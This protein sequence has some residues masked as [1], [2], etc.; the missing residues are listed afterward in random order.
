MP[1]KRGQVY[2]A[3]QVVEAIKKA[4]GYVSKAADILGCDARTVYNYAERY[5]SVQ[6]AINHVRETRHDYVESALMKR[7]KAQDTTAIIFYLKTQAKQR[8]YVERQEVTGSDG[9]DI[10]QRILITYKN[11]EIDPQ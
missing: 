11:Q 3:T 2:T 7:I 6:E 9:A 10:K 5:P 8:G 1:K 4:R